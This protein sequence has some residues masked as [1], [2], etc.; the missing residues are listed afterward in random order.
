MHEEQWKLNRDTDYDQGS[1]KRLVLK[2]SYNAEKQNPLLRK[3]SLRMK[4]NIIMKATDRTEWILKE[5]RRIK[6]IGIGAERISSFGRDC[7]R[8]MGI[9][10]TGA[11]LIDLESTEKDLDNA[12]KFL[13]CLIS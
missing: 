11:D 6:K 4:W 2:V 7:R 3:K 13:R 10:R 9:R 5:R 8:D 1:L 12:G